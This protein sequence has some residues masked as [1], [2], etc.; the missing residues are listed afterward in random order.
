MLGTFLSSKYNHFPIKT[1]NFNSNKIIGNDII[2]IDKLD[3]KSIEIWHRRLG[4]FYQRNLPKYLELH[5]IKT[6]PCIDCKISKMRKGSHKGQT[7]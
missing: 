3:D 4:H 7:P 2:H 6:P 5:N 1:Q